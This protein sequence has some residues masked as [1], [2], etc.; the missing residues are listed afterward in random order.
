MPRLPIALSLLAMAACQAGP[1]GHSV[2]PPPP[3]ARPTDPVLPVA[4]A[5]WNAGQDASPAS[6]PGRVVPGPIRHHAP[7]QEHTIPDDRPSWLPGAP[8]DPERYT[9]PDEWYSD[10]IAA[11]GSSPPA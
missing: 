2:A 5:N 11:L 1:P 6:E 9:V 4:R 7:R 10:T 3:P 8:D